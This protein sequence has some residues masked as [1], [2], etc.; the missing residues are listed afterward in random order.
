MLRGYYTASY[1]MLSQQRK[2]EMMANNLAN[3]NTP[4]YKADQASIRAF[5]E[6]LLQRFEQQKTGEFN[7]PMNKTIGSLNTG[8]YLQETMPKF[9]QGGIHETELKTD[10]ALLDISIPV[11]PETGR[12]GSVFFMV[13]NGKGET[14]YTRNGNFTLDSR[15]FLTTASGLYV[16]DREGKRIQLS[17]EEFTLDETGNITGAAGERARLG[18]AYSDNPMNMVKEGDGLYRAQ[19][20]LP[21]AYGADGVLF[22]IQQG[23]LEQSN[24]DAAQTMTEMMTAY[25]SFEANQKVLQAY[26]T[27]LQKTVNEVGKL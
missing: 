22:K 24:V 20:E 16:L 8:V 23:F 2:A 18:V 1:G 26:D 15:G 13:E 14:R 12:A 21:D 25:R 7:L 11:N 17:S 6:M 5:P 9:L 3:A 19:N 27:S 4:G 10:A